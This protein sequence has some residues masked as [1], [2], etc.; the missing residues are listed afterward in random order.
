MKVLIATLALVVIGACS[1]AGIGDDPRNRKGV[2]GELSWRVVNDGDGQAAFL[3]RPGAAPDLVLWCRERGIL[4]LRAH[5]FENPG[6]QPDLNLTT[7]G[8]TIALN[9]VRRQGGVRAGDRKLVEGA[10]AF[11][12]L[13]VAPI[14]K[15]AGNLSVTS[16]G[17]V[18][19]ARNTD[20]TNI[21]PSFA[22]ACLS[23]S[24]YP[25]AKTTP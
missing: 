19:E 10:V 13:Q 14:L 3:S 16:G 5:V 24:A 22:A 4:T 15:Q 21:L 8:G 20:P 6:S 11:N 7:P 12:D 1:P 9:N 18:F 23:S 25:K 17:I 2:D